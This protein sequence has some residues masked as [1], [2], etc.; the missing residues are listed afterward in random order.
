MTA[1]EGKQQLG[2]PVAQ[3]RLNPTLKVVAR[4]FGAQS[5]AFEAK[6]CDLIERIEHPEARIKLEAINDLHGI[7]EP[8]VLRPQIAVCVDDPA[9][10]DQ[11]DEQ[12]CV[13]AQETALRVV[14]ASHQSQGQPETA[15]KQ[16]LAV[17]CEAG[18]PTGQVGDSGD[19]GWARV[20]IK[21][22]QHIHYLVQLLNFEASRENQLI[23][24][25]RLVKSMHDDDPIDR[26]TRPSYGQAAGTD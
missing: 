24:H 8:N 10:P 14:D 1:V 20:P 25:P 6:V 12:L 26:L 21:P 5:L 2:A 18:C 19:E 22:G 23:E 15:I 3:C 4:P 7:A 11:V 16:E 13:T 17:I 9:F